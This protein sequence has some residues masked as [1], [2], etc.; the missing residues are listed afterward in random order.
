M[1]FIVEKRSARPC[2]FALSSD[3]AISSSKFLSHAIRWGPDYAGKIDCSRNDKRGEKSRDIK[4]HDGLIVVDLGRG[5]LR[6]AGW[7]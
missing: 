3:N 7:D 5:E 4:F 1:V 6:A 2:S